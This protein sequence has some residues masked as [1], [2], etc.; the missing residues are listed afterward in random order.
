MHRKTLPV[1]NREQDL[2]EENITR[3]VLPLL[4]VGEEEKEDKRQEQENGQNASAVPSWL[5]L[6]TN[7]IR[8]SIGLDVPGAVHT[9]RTPSK[10]IIF[11]NYAKTYKIFYA[12]ELKPEK[13]LDSKLVVIMGNSFFF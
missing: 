3:H 10:K 2:E 1:V 8:H 5:K 4:S 7:R 6:E 9:I 13:Q 12:L 11:R